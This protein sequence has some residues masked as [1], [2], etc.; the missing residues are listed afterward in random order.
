MCCVHLLILRHN[1]DHVTE[2][3]CLLLELFNVDIYI[4]EMFRL[5]RNVFEELVHI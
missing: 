4:T 3:N 2:Y 5:L 1:W